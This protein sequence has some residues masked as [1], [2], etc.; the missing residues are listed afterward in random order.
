M[1]L[2]L[3]KHGKVSRLGEMESDLDVWTP[4]LQVH[5]E[6]LSEVYSLPPGRD[7]ALLNRSSPLF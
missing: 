1:I 5:S 7:L 2:V 4:V 6:H 3:T